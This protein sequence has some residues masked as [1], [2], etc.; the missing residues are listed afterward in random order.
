MSTEGTFQDIYEW[1]INLQALF[2]DDR[3]TVYNT[4]LSTTNA[5]R[6]SLLSNSTSTLL[7]FKLLSFYSFGSGID[8]KQ[9]VGCLTYI[10]KEDKRKSFTAIGISTQNV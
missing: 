6:C 2:I 5:T 4:S 9:S 7:V 10:D 1:R 8:R 3:G